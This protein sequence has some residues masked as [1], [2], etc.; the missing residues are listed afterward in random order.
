M[1]VI[2]DR[3]DIAEYN[4]LRQL[5]RKFPHLGE[6]TLYEES[7][8]NRWSLSHSRVELTST[9]FHRF[10]DTILRVHRNHLRELHIF[11]LLPFDQDIYLAIRD[12]APNLRSLTFTANID[13]S[14]QEIFTNST[15]WVSGI[16]ASL[17][18][19]KLQSCQGV[20]LGYFA[21]NVLDG[22]YGPSLEEVSTIVCG[23]P[24]YE[25][26]P[27]IP[28]IGTPAQASI[29]RL[30]IDHFL[31]W[32]LLAMSFIPVRDLSLTQFCPQSFV[33][34][35]ILLE[36]RSSRPN[37]AYTAFPGLEQ[38]RLSPRLALQEEVAKLDEKAKHA[39]Q[40]LKE[41]CLRRGVALSMDADK[42]L[43]SDDSAVVG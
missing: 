16:T 8:E 38:L 13:R 2:H 27:Y 4:I 32:E 34:L 3:E 33:E 35:P 25:D 5:V 19:I 41:V 12:N 1:T 6:I 28:P 37:G 31:L 9:F 22:V 29:N 14:L 39:F 36:K 24:D 30:W 11:T 20:H 26:I 7:Y 17:D 23:L 43:I 40:E 15:P 42:Y 18:K 10:L 21:R